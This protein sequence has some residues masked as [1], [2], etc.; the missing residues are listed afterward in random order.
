MKDGVQRIEFAA[1][2]RRLSAGAIGCLEWN[3]FLTVHYP[4]EL[5]EEVRRNVVRLSIERGATLTWSDSERE[6]LQHYSRL[7]R[8]NVE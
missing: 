6:V 2:L 1:F 7:L 5:L 4:D 3:R 8:E